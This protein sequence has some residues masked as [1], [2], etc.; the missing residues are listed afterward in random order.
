MDKTHQVLNEGLRQEVVCDARNVRAGVEQH[1]LAVDNAADVIRT[2][3][4]CID[5]ADANLVGHYGKVWLCVL[6]FR[7]R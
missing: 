3:E 2:V 1:F 7:N 5:T 4:R 6:R